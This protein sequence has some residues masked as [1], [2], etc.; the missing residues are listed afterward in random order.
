MVT[1]INPRT[2]VISS[3]HRPVSL[4]KGSNVVIQATT[5]QQFKTNNNLFAIIKVYYSKTT[6]FVILLKYI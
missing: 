4:Q 3:S 2:K 6:P 1:L 5:Q